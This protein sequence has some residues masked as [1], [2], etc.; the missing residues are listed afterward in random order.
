MTETRAAQIVL[1]VD[2]DVTIRLLARETLEQA[3]FRVE[4]AVDGQSAVIGFQRVRPDIVLLDVQMPLMDGFETCTAL[5]ALDRGDL[6]PVLMMTGLDDSDSINRSYEAGATDFITKPVEWPMLGHRVRY[7]LRANRA[8]LDLTQSQAR[9]VDAQRIAQLG[10]WDWH[11]GAD[12]VECSDEIFR[13]IGRTRE[14]FHERFNSL[15]EVVHPEDQ[16]VVKQAID[17]ALR[18]RES[19]NLDFRILRP[20]GSIRIVHEQGEVHYDSDGNPVRMQG[21]TQDVTERKRAEEQ[22]RQLALYDNLTGLPNRHLFR[23]QLDHAIGVAKRTGQAL[24]MLSLDLDRFKRVNDTLGHQGGDELLKEAASRLAKTLRPTDYV[25]RDESDEVQA[26][27]RPGGDEFTLV[28]AVAQ[29]QDGAKIARRILDALARPF[30]L[31]E[32]EVVVSASIGIAVYPLDGL[33]SESLIRNADAAMYHAKEQGKNN[34]QYYNRSMNTSAIERLA[35]ETKLHRALERAEFSLYFQPKVEVPTGAVTGVEALIRWADP[36]RG[37]VS[38]AEFIPL[39]EETG[40]IIPI[41]EWALRQACAE[42]AAWRA[43]GIAVVPVA[44]N[45]S[46]RQFHQRDI[47]GMVKRALREFDIPPHLIEIE[48]TEST[49]MH[50]AEA[51][52]ETLENLK[53]LGVHIAI[54]D[55]GTGYSSLSYLKRFPIDCLKLDRSL[56]VG[57]PGGQDDAPIAQAVIT[58][59]HALRI[60]VVAEGVETDAQRQFLTANGCDEMQGYYFS[61]P[62]PAE[63]CTRL[64][65]GKR[66]LPSR[67]PDLATPVIVPT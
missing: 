27:G 43:T 10:H 6:A 11:V 7:L 45:I 67:Q 33:D 18:R 8:F 30:R 62:V 56:V 52:R 66:T 20:D 19:F 16:P 53:A 55:F 3:G 35:L 21:T 32:N 23:E 38:P 48:I 51:A 25:T 17:A 28:M 29:P 65:R 5:R 40:L 57:L 41:G 49:A 15:L 9:L 14:D 61:R 39:A 13:I 46:P 34:Y 44:V 1:V 42:L 58:M 2:D 50:H 26:V 24:V 37:L 47:V 31:G 12:R 4:E 22:I 54:D 64:L 36:E 59:A 63:E 60:K